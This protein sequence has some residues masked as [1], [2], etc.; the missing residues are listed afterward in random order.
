MIPLAN[1]DS[2]EVAVRSLQFTQIYIYIY[3]Y[4]PQRCLG[5]PVSNHFRPMSEALLTPES[6][7]SSQIFTRQGSCGVDK[8]E[9]PQK[10]TKNNYR[11]IKR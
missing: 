9:G 11:D 5:L 7:G 10:E 3:T 6:K 2:S 8:N 4:I 1:H